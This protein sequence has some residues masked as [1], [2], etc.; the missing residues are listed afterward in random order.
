VVIFAL[1]KN[2]PARGFRL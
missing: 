1:F 2:P